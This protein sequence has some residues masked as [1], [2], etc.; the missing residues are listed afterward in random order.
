M[1]AIIPVPTRKGIEFWTEF[2]L[3]F[4][5]IIIGHPLDYNITMQPYNMLNVMDDLNRELI[6][7]ESF[8]TIRNK[9]YKELF[10]FDDRILNVLMTYEMIVKHDSLLSNT[11]IDNA[12]KVLL[13]VIKEERKFL[14]HKTI[15]NDLE[16][17]CYK[18]LACYDINQKIVEFDTLI[19]LI[20]F[21]PDLLRRFNTIDK[22]YL[23]TLCSLFLSSYRYK[24][25]LEY[26]K[27]CEE[28]GIICNLEKF[29]EMR[30]LCG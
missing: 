4:C 21:D 10:K 15:Y 17:Q 12:I 13:E 23:S 1:K 27:Q 18:V 3:I 14:N 19:Q 8:E 2:E 29:L 9:T 20:H 7:L 6:T 28:Y 25:E 11:T 24:D 30:H 16:H 26:M 22:L 5:P